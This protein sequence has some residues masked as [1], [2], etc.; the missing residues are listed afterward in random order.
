M[1]GLIKATYEMALSITDDR[2]Q[3]NQEY[4]TRIEA[5]EHENWQLKTSEEEALAHLEKEQSKVK[6]LLQ[7]IAKSNLGDLKGPDDHHFISKFGEV[8]LS[9]N[10]WV[11]KYYMRTTPEHLL[12]LEPDIGRRLELPTVDYADVCSN[13]PLY[14]IGALVGSIILR[15]LFITPMTESPMEGI[16][17]YIQ[18]SCKVLR[19]QLRE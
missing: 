15:K 19:H 16:S 13:H 5:L 9:I 7:D 18:D 2:K 4:K 1:I 3:K 6:K 8:F 12:G 14:V 17:K 11:L 10:E